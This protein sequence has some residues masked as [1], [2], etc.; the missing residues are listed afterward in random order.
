MASTSQTELMTRLAKS[1]IETNET[2]KAEW[3]IQN[4]TEKSLSQDYRM[5]IVRHP[6]ERL[7]SAYMW[8]LG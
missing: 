1:E 5:M 4:L 3:Y 8:F 2:W 6:F 7:L